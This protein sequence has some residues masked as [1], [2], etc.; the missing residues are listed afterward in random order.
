MWRLENPCRVARDEV[1]SERWGALWGCPMAERRAA[2]AAIG[3]A[4]G[5]PELLLLLI[6]VIHMALRSRRDLVL[7]N[8]LLR[9]QLAV[10]RRPKPRPRLKTRDKL[11]WLLGR[12]FCSDWRRHL[13]LV[14]PD[15][16][17]RWHRQ[18]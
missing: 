15:T 17:V 1:P 13:V 3:H 9:H 16:V 5:M 11:L 14:T 2:A 12:R 6:A 7:E 18:G 10:A 8:L 4:A